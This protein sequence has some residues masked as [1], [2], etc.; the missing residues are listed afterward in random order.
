MPS[1][2][3]S[4]S[5]SMVPREEIISLKEATVF[6]ASSTVNPITWSVSTDVAA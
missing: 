1:P 5:P 3:M 6:S 4:S 2:M